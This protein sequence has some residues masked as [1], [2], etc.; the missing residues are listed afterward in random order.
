MKFG[1]VF[2]QFGIN[3]LLF[4]AEVFEVMASEDSRS[5]SPRRGWGDRKWRNERG[6]DRKAGRMDSDSGRTSRARSWFGKQYINKAPL[7][8]IKRNPHGLGKGKNLYDIP[9][10]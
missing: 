4:S 10:E 8:R 6:S 1:I 9:L 5:T 7:G 3:F 2:G